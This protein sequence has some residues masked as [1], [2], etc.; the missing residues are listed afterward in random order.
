MSGLVNS[1]RELPYSF[2]PMSW[3]KRLLPGSSA[4]RIALPPASPWEGE[5]VD[6]DRFWAEAWVDLQKRQSWLAKKAG[7]ANAAWVV[8]QPAGLIHFERTDGALVTAPVQIIGSWNPRSEVFTW[9]W[10]HPSVATRL[11]ANAERTRWFGEKNDL[12]ELTCPQVKA[13]EAEAWR[14]TAV[15][16]KVNAARGAYRGPTDSGTIVFMSLGDLKLKT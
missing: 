1:A 6:V 4:S 13:T 2:R 14:L 10:D 12:Q 7:L 3:L 9:G 16:V 11:R 5:H 8:D 15:S